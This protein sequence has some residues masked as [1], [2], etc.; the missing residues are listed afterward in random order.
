MAKTASKT[1]QQQRNITQNLNI[2][3]DQC[4]D[5]EAQAR[6]LADTIKARRQAIA[7]Y[8]A[9][10]GLMR[11]TSRAGNEAVRI[12]ADRRSWSVDDL[13]DYLSPEE[14]RELCPPRPAGAKLAKLMESGTHRLLDKC[15]K[16]TTSEKLELRPAPAPIEKP[17]VTERQ[18]RAHKASKRR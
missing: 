9:D 8:M 1:A 14:F 2:L 4:V 12:P 15:C 10:G 18:R 6:D 7:E 5:L 11:F 17:R 3:V 16:V 13:R